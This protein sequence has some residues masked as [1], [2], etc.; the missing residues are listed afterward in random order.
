[1]HISNHYIAV[2]PIEKPKSEG[3][4]TVEVQNDFVYKGS[5]TT[6]PFGA[7]ARM[8]GVMRSGGKVAKCAP[9]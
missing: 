9:L 1:M 6:P 2:E 4:E 5:S 7:P 8:Q 3:Y